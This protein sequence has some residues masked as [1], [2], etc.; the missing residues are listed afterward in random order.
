[1]SAGRTATAASV[2]GPAR[3]ATER[4]RA[5]SGQAQILLARCVFV[6]GG[7]VVSVVLA[8]GLGP[9][10]LGAYGVLMTLLTWIEMT[11]GGGMPGATTKV[12]ADNPDDAAA[13]EQTSR[14]L[15]LAMGL[16]LFVIGW[17]A[18]PALA[19]LLQMP[20]GAWLFRLTF[21]DAPLMAAFYAA[22]GMLFGRRRFALYAA[23]LILMML[24]KL[25]GVLLL[26][27][28]GLGLAGAMIAH[29]ASTA[30]TLVFVLVR[31]P[32][33][34][35][36]PRLGLARAMLQVALALVSYGFALQVLTNL[37]LWQLKSLTP[38]ESIAAGL[39]VAAL[40]IAR[41]LTVIPSAIS[42]VVFTSVSHAMAARDDPAAARHVQDGLR[43]TLLLAAP[44]VALLVADAAPII[45]LLFGA[46]YDPATPVL[47][48]LVV[49]FA[50]IA[51]FDVLC[52]AR[53]AAGRGGRV[54]GLVMVMALVAMGAGWLLIPAAE[55]TGAALAQL[56]PLLLGALLA[57]LL[58]VRRFGRI[59]ALWPALRILAMAV[60][61]GI[62]ATLLPGEG[63][64]VLPELAL[65]GLA[66]LAGLALLGELRREDL[67]AFGIG[68]RAA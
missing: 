23:A 6:I 57:A 61:T 51:L 40:N 63:L 12:L 50:L 15:C 65:C 4:R 24:V 59:L 35:A 32:P 13:V 28:I 56:L 60:A 44:A 26:L 48:A 2:G 17:L 52:Q 46:P 8:R 29:L 30:A 25:G 34:R 11:I 5:A 43:Y 20:D 55:A 14:L 19:A 58:A 1:V 10:Q 3:L 22:Q 39:F 7:M 33:C 47:R 31:M 18:A 45:H 21:A 42:G 64:W 38:A 68:R 9:A 49:V 37:N 66:Y 62:L 36:A 16:S 41:V 67:A 54:P 27:A 53:M